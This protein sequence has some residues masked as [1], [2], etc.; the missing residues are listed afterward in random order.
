MLRPPMATRAPAAQAGHRC[1]TTEPAI[2]DPAAA[3]VRLASTRGSSG[4]LPAGE[5]GVARPAADRASPSAPTAEAGEGP[6]AALQGRFEEYFQ[7]EPLVLEWW[8]TRAQQIQ[9]QGA[10]P[11]R[12]D[13]RNE[14]AQQGTA[15]GPAN[16]PTQ[17]LTQ[18]GI[19]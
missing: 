7:D 12:Q 19:S 1:L 10:D 17:G 5:P 11:V 9:P 6:P 3:P 2:V 14:S 8:R 16:A 4:L 13:A 18:P 15:E